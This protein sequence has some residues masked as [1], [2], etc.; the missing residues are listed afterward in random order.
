LK[1]I[2]RKQGIFKREKNIIS[3]KR[4]I[5]SNSTLRFKEHSKR[6]KR[7][8]LKEKGKNKE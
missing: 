1:K 5:S 7:R 6:M 2:F 8:Y 4:R 3:K